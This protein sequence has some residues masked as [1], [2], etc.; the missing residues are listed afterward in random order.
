MSTAQ[1]RRIAV[2]GAGIGGLC[3]AA[4][5]VRRG[6]QVEVFEQA[7]ALGEIGAGLQISPNGVKV[8]RT[9][10]L[11][12]A[13]ELAGV[14]PRRL[15]MRDWKTGLV[16]SSTGI[17]GDFERA[18]GAPYY[19][20]HRADLLAMLG[21]AAVGATLRTGCAVLSVEDDG[22]GA[23][24]R[25]ASG[26]ERFDAVIGA[27]GIHSVVRRALHADQAPRF[28][29]NV[30]FRALVPA[31]D[32]LR[33]RVERDAT[34]WMG[35]GGHV[36]HY[37]VRS[38]RLLNIVAVYETDRWTD[39]SWTQP[40]QVA[41]LVDCFRGW[42]RSLLD[43]L[44]RAGQ[45]NRWALYD[46][47]PLSAWGRGRITLLGDAAHPMLP[48]LAQGAVMAIED[49]C[50]LADAL[51]TQA[52]TAQA[53]RRYESAR[54]GRTSRLQLAARAQ[55]ESM[56]RSGALDA[57]RRNARLFLRSRFSRDDQLRKG[58]GLYGFDATAPR[59]T[60]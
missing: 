5:L 31:D 23:L 22:E 55:G 36:V 3:A 52:D 17:D 21:Q 28:T 24:V 37:F 18:Y 43:V 33:R 38:A 40:A 60:D 46:R 29:G 12:E 54:V 34:I 11:G 14:R 30:A 59:R 42:N 57:W 53:L 35:P 27:D 6:F 47:D 9:V 20:V 44:G 58:Q 7:T 32:A 26:A 16:V 48:F 10:G 1:A 4:L 8:L 25:T 13:L 50:V 15:T 2:V 49:A 19:H 51:A 45:C 39:E 41:E 56:H